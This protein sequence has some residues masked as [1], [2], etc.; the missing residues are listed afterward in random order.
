MLPASLP[1]VS[2]RHPAIS[3]ARGFPLGRPAAAARRLAG[4]SAW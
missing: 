1:G 3:V 4:M 2:V